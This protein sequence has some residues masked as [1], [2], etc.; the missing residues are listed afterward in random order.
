MI[1]TVVGAGLG[2]G[3]LVAIVNAVARRRTTKVDA[4]DRLSDGALKWVNEFQENANEARFEAAAARR[5][6][7]EAHAQMRAV[8]AEAEWLAG[9]LQALRRAIM[10]PDATLD[11][12]RVLVGPDANH[13]GTGG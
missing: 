9:Q 12:L 1:A 10:A 8:R 11:R 7:T 4:A 6:A 13:N 5:E 2:G 3:G